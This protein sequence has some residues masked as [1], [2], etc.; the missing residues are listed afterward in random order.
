M[1]SVIAVLLLASA[2]AKTPSGDVAVEMALTSLRQENSIFLQMQGQVEFGRKPL[3]KTEPIA[4][5]AYWT[6]SPQKLGTTVQSEVLEYK[7]GA[8]T[9]RLVADGANV[10]NYNIVAH[11]YRATNYRGY[12]PQHANDVAGALYLL[13]E[14]SSHVGAHTTRLLEQTYGGS[15]ATFQTWIPGAQ[16][17]TIPDPEIKDMIDVIYSLGTPLRRQATFKILTGDKTLKLSSIE[18]ED[19]STVD[20]Q[21]RTVTWTLTPSPVVASSADFKPYPGDRVADWKVAAGGS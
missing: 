13:R 6:E 17:K 19:I 12:A 5:D 16:V 18:Y 20:G 14:D 4:C 1:T 15:A 3:S 8:L 2:Q 9:T 10:W 7:G 11:E 21:S